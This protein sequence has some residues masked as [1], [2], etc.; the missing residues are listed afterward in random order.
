[1]WIFLRDLIVD[2]NVSYKWDWFLEVSVEILVKKKVLSER[3]NMGRLVGKRKWGGRR[4][5]QK[6]NELEIE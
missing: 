4:A 2:R 3:I 5:Q 6:K 1:M